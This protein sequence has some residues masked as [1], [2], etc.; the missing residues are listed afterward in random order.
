MKSRRNVSE[1]VLEALASR[2]VE[3]LE[4]GCVN[5]PLPDPVISDPDFPPIPPSD[6]HSIAQMGLGLLRADRG[7]FDRH[8]SI[9]VDLI[10]PHRMNLTDDPFEVHE[11][12]LIKRSDTLVERLLFA[13]ATEWLA[14]ALDRSCPDPD[15]WWLAIA[16]TNGLCDKAH[17]QP[18]H[19]GY[20]LVES[21]ALAE[22]PGTWHTQPE[23]TSANMDWNPHGMV[24]RTTSVTAH[25]A[26]AKAACW[27]MEQ[28]ENGGE[29]RR[30]LLVEWCRLLLERKE[31][32]EP[33]GLS[34]ILIR[35]ANDPSPEIASRVI[36]CLARMI[37]NDKDSGLECV[38]VLSQ[39]DE[40]LVRRGMADVLTRLFRRITHDA[41][42][43][44]ESMLEDE[45]ESVL[46]AASA[47]VGDL[48]FLDKDMWA[49]KIRELCDHDSK[50]VRRNLVH[51]LRDYMEEFDSDERGILPMLWNDG[52]EVV[53]TRLREFLIRMEEVDNE[54][55]SSTIKQLADSD[56]ESLWTLME[57]K[58]EERTRAWKAWLYEGGVIP[59]Q[60]SRPEIHV[61][62]MTEG[63]LPEL[64]DALNMLDDMGFLD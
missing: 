22:R 25:E 19:Q 23:V 36:M 7:M 1:K 57:I 40:I 10:V 39:S 43:L 15:R 6:S 42:P 3:V 11:R 32:I 16:M 28:M 30:L 54:R 17:G 46:A 48:R 21:I 4:A 60:K 35:R 41:I 5:W 37:E 29:D 26:G 51:T 61:S 56:L 63:E 59:E 18:V 49:D 52:D 33:L 44:L 53:L 58:D 34:Q 45:D 62:D 20:H 14:Q 2:L 38:R 12:W 64:D 31:L 27:L 50:V 9:V 24:P 55:F 13:M 47:T 8:L